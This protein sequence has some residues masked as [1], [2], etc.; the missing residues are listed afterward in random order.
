MIVDFYL[1]DEHGEETT[2]LEQLSLTCL[3]PYLVGQSLFLTDYRVKP[4]KRVAYVIVRVDHVITV[5]SNEQLSNASV[6]V[7]LQVQD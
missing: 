6:E 2:H 1:L 5:H 3:Q 7:H 4:S